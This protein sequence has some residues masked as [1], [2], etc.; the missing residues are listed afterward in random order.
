[1]SLENRDPLSAPGRSSRVL[2]KGMVIEVRGEA[3]A[4]VVASPGVAGSTQSNSRSL[5]SIGKL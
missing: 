4:S 2:R 1:M 5:G 3:P